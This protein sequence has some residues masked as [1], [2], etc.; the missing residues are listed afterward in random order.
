MNLGKTAL[1]GTEPQG[2]SGTEFHGQDALLPPSKQR[3]STWEK[4][5]ELTL[6]TGHSFFLHP[7]SDS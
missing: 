4:L 7:S 1:L 2:I 3:Q 5:K 6:T